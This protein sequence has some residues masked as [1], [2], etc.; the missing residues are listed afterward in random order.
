MFVFINE[1]EITTHATPHQDHPQ[2]YAEG[3]ALPP[4]FTYGGPG[5][6]AA[7]CAALSTPIPLPASAPTITPSLGDQIE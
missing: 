6:P 7:Q 5:A 4:S 1:L 3:H 2:Y